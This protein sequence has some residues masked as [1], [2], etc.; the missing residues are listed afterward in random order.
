HALAALAAM[1]LG[2]AL[3]TLSPT[4]VRA[5]GDASRVARVLER[6]QPSLII[7]DEIDGAVALDDLRRPRESTAVSRAFANV[8]RGTVARYLLTSGSTDAPKLVTTT[9]GMLTANQQQIAQAW[10]FVTQ[11]ELVL[12]DWLPWSHTFGASHNFNL[13]LANG[14]TFHID[15]G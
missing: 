15:D 11:R 2:V 3:C 1:H 14:G 5:A 6:L 7:G 12:L 13:A 10:P 4:W 8:H 9:H